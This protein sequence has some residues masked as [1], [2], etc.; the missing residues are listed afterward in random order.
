MTTNLRPIDLINAHQA[1]LE[2]VLDHE[3]GD[4]PRVVLDFLNVGPSHYNPHA[5]GVL[6]AIA[7]R[8]NRRITET[9]AYDIASYVRS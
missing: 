7:R 6:R 5:R 9:D 4:T 2:Y 8:L 1:M 3:L